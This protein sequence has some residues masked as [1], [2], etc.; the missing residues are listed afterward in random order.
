MSNITELFGNQSSQETDAEPNFN[1]TL[2]L[3]DGDQINVQG[4]LVV[5][6]LFVAICRGEGVIHWLAPFEDVK[7]VVNNGPAGNNALN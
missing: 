5:N 2:T 3:K 7:R 1:Y 6:S 4:Y